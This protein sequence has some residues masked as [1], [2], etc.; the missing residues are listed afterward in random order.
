MGAQPVGLVQGS[1][2]NFYGTTARGGANGAGS[3]FKITTNGAL[4]SLYSFAG[5][6]DGATPDGAL[7]QG[8]DGFFYGITYAGG[9]YTN[10]SGQG[11]G[12]VFK[13]DTNGA[14][15]TLH[16]FAGASDGA[17]PNGSLAL[18]SDGYFYGTTY[19]GGAY[20][21]QSGPGQGTVFKMSTNG[22][23]T[24]LYSFTGGNDGANP[25]GL[26][27]GSDGYF[28][29]TTRY[30]G[31]RGGSWS[32][33]GSGTVFK[34]ATNGALTP[35]YSFAGADGAQPNPLV[36]GSD[37]FF[38]GTTQNGGDTY[39]TWSPLGEGTIFKISTGGALTSL[40]YFSTNDGGQQP[41]T[42]L[43]EGRD[44]YFY[45]TAGTGNGYTYGTVFRITTN[46]DLTGLWAFGGE[47][48]AYPCSQLV[49]GDDGYFYGTTAGFGRKPY[50]GS[51]YRVST[52]GAL[53]TLYEFMDANDG[54]GPT[55]LVQGRDG[56]LYGTTSQGGLYS[57]FADGGVQGTVFQIS[58]N[59][60][61]NTLHW[62]TG[63][64]DG[65]YPGPIMQGND[66][67]L[68]GTTFGGGAYRD[69][70]GYYQGTAFRA[71]T[72]GG[73][74]TL[75]S[76]TGTNDG[77]NPQGAL[78]QGGD[79]LLYGVC[80]G[81][82]LNYHGTVFQISTGGALTTLHLFTG[83]DGG[84]PQAALIQGSDGFLYGT[85]GGG[86]IDSLGTV[87][88]I[89]TSGALTT[90]HSFTGPEGSYP[91]A[92]L[93]QGRDCDFYGTTYNGGTNGG[94]GTV[95]KITANGTLT[96]LYSFTGAND[97]LN[98]NGLV[99]GSDGNFYG[100]TFYGG[101]YSN[102][103]GSFGTIF[104]ITPNG[105][106]TTLYAFGSVTN[107]SGQSVDGAHPN[108]ALVHGIDGGFYGTTLAGGLADYGTVFR[109][110]APPQPPQLTIL[111][112]PA[113]IVLTWR[114]NVGGF[115][116][117]STTNLVG[118][119]VWATNSAQPVLVNGWYTVTNPISGAQRFFRLS[120]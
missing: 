74:I 107:V 76:F 4:T 85:T 86:G 119:T 120:Q 114:A 2:G 83:L 67:N 64:N 5:G 31:Y 34:I 77:G 32:V 1:D 75:H 51:V 13:I 59:G 104:R 96:S 10:E 99:Q 63:G 92:A 100:T 116:L 8:N 40:H 105:A 60:A 53:F 17:G 47:D 45:G 24:S 57:D 41:I 49:Q 28:Y 11:Q 115:S 27:L 87:F 72:G 33:I 39:T 29:G 102:G 19:G 89:S 23:L 78:V 79:G 20:T 46:G 66:G 44:G 14:L 70:Y 110:T 55:P 61:L 113:S 62:F 37:G 109:L 94:G 56:Y 22:A 42:A 118:P 80:G 97:G 15:T 111:L 84:S 117:Q 82:G 54:A 93:V 7:V 16:S 71:G 98:P 36:R 103:S 18:G 52:N 3:L 25:V 26:A 50:D 12:T 88:K 65:A 68:Y 90:L 6:S 108:G 48:S 38:Y 106:L 101:S 43:V 9:G 73:L 91:F 69:Q 81:G 35:L 58:T 30:G 21:N 95:F 112:K